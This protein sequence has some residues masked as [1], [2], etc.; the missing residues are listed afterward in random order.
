MN[1]DQLR[2]RMTNGFHAFT[3][4]LSDGRKFPV[5]HPEFIAVGRNIVVVIGD[6]DFANLIDPLH[7][8][9]IE[10]HTSKE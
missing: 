10:E 6:D 3:L 8:V 9:S 1:F 7:I 5:R 4:H 2:K